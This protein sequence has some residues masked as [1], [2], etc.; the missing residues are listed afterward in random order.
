MSN[1]LIITGA[2]KKLCGSI[3]PNLIL[4]DDKTHCKI[5]NVVLRK[6]GLISYERSMFCLGMTKYNTTLIADEDLEE[7][8]KDN[9]IILQNSEPCETISEDLKEDALKPCE[10]PEDC[11][12]SKDEEGIKIEII[13]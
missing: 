13:R 4:S 2:S 3:C 10:C 6:R 1:I 12:R 7:F 11:E 8:A 5:G 9:D